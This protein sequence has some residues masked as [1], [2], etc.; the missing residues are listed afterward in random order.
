MA[1]IPDRTTSFQSPVVPGGLY[2][3]PP[4]VQIWDCNKGLGIGLI[5]GFV[6]RS[7]TLPGV[8]TA[9]VHLYTMDS[10]FGRRWKKGLCKKYKSTGP[11]NCVI[12]IDSPAAFSFFIISV[13]LTLAK[14]SLEIRRLTF[15]VKQQSPRASWLGLTGHMP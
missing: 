15:I 7:G 9:H 8:D 13:L 6:L 12:S 14:I 5:R 11:T 2:H 10:V 4:C 3:Y 1:L